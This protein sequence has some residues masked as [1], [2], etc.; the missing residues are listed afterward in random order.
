[1]QKDNGGN[2]MK[3]SY[4][5]LVLIA[6]GLGACTFPALGQSAPSE[7]QIQTAI[8]G[9]RQASP[10]DTSQPTLTEILP[11]IET[12]APLEAPTE[13]PTESLPPTD[14]PTVETDSST[15]DADSPAV[16]NPLSDA[17]I[18]SSAFL[19]NEQFL[20]TIQLPQDVSGAYR[21]EA[22]GKAFTCQV[23]AQYPDR[24]YCSGPTL[25]SGTQV[26]VRVFEVDSD[27]VLFEDEL[28]VPAALAAPPP[29]PGGGGGGQ[30]SPGE[31]PTRPYPY[32]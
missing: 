17:F 8:A 7:E 13:V 5:F 32:P 2:R 23:L 3:Y 19:A 15:E 9:T 18:Y 1:M 20:V 16:E 27:E 6:L 24:L 25:D 21:A 22:D 29:R 28:L 26:L 12:E 4:P 30:P 14:T 31:P 11:P 10:S